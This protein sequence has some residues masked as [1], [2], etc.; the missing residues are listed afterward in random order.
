[1][2]GPFFFLVYI[3]DLC[4]DLNCDVK[5]IADDTSRELFTPV[6]NENISAQNL[7]NDLRKMHE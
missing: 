6:F 7:N 2:L 1:M 4:D 5:L 3:N